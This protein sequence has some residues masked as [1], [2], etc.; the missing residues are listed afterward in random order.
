M[1]SRWEVQPSR[2]FGW[3]YRV[4]LLGEVWGPWRFAWTFERAVKKVGEMIS[5]HEAARGLSK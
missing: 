1:P 4:S 2:L 5:R 3:Y